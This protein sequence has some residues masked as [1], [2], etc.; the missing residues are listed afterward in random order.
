MCDE[1]QES[2]VE[3]CAQA[4][5][6]AEDNIPQEKAT[7]CDV[8]K[9]IQILKLRKAC[10]ITGNP[11]NASGTFQGYHWF[12]S[13]ISSTTALDCPIFHHLGRKMK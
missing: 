12:T 13:N 9:L 7:P 8:R 1:H 2:G 6:E 4:L 11:N 3:S 10:G 5:L